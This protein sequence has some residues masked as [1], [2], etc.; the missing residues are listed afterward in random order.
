MMSALP[1]FWL[2]YLRLLPSQTCGLQTALLI[3]Q[4]DL[5][6]LLKSSWLSPLSRYLRLFFPNLKLPCSPTCPQSSD[7]TNITTS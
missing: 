7:L 3:P 4:P 1:L 5:L 2:S 6:T